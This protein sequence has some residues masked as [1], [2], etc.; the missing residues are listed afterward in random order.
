MVPQGR[1]LSGGSTS[2][3]IG[4]GSRPCHPHECVGFVPHGDRAIFANTMAF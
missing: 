2:G 1:G 3:G 4:Q